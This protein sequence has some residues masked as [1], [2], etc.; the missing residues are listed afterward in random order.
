[1]QAVLAPRTLYIAAFNIFNP[2]QIPEIKSDEV[3]TYREQ[4]LETLLQHYGVPKA[5]VAPNRDPFTKKP[6][7]ALDIQT[8]WKTFEHY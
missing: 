5:A 8:E 1:L 7:I 6:L 2:K 3:R 4:S